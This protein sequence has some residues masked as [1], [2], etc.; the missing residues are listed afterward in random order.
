MLDHSW[1]RLSSPAQPIRK[2]IG[3]VPP[4]TKASMPAHI[5]DGATICLRCT[6]IAAGI[7]RRTGTR[8]P[9]PGREESRSAEKGDR[10]RHA[11]H[12]NENLYMTEFRRGATICKACGT[13]T[14][15][16]PAAEPDAPTARSDRGNQTVHSLQAAQAHSDQFSGVIPACLHRLPGGRRRSDATS[17]LLSRRNQG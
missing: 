13:A 15:V 17:R 10:A 2:T 16:A 7:R 3:S 9:A 5:P 6:R 4:A 12:A 8:S 14:A 1:I 11:H